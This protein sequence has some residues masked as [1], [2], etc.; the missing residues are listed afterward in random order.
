MTAEAQKRVGVMAGT[1]EPYGFLP[2]LA[3][4]LEKT[5]HLGEGGWR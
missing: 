5:A 4:F 3:G 1:P 2:V